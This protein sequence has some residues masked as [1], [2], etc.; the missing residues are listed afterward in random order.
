MDIESKLTDR[1]VFITG[2]DGFVGSHLVN[3]LVDCG[4]DVHVFVRATSSGELNNIRHRSDD[5][6][7]HRG[8]LRDHLF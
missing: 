3:R 2:A 8:D 6:T 4:A 5:V 1:L 7:V